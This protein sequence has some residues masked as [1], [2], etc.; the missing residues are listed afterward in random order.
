MPGGTQPPCSCLMQNWTWLWS[1][2]IPLHFQAHLVLGSTRALP[3]LLLSSLPWIPISPSPNLKTSG[4]QRSPQ[5]PHSQHREL[6]PVC[7]VPLERSRVTPPPAPSP[8]PPGQGGWDNSGRP[9]CTRGGQGGDWCRQSGHTGP[10]LG[11]RARGW[12]GLK[13]P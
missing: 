4:P 6:T 8:A 5:R 13:L 11:S 3:L 7:S 2:S 9:P 12:E 1:G 10:A